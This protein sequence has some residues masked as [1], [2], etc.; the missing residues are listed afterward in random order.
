MVFVD[1]PS[2][3]ARG[4]HPEPHDTAYRLCCAFGAWKKVC[5]TVARRRFRVRRRGA[6]HSPNSQTKTGSSRK[7][8]T[9]RG[10]VFFIL[11]T[12]PHIQKM[13]HHNDEILPSPQEETQKHPSDTQRQTNKLTIPELVAIILSSTDEV[14]TQTMREHCG[15]W[16]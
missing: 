13:H 14:G 4:L 7:K 16:G 8:R 10:S 2:T 15:V 1:L 3:P 9:H 12:S 5:S 11:K 6:I